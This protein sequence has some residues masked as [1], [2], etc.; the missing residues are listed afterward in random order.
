MCGVRERLHARTFIGRSRRMT[1]KR[2][3]G[4]ELSVS[5]Q[6]LFPLS[7]CVAPRMEGEACLLGV[8]LLVH[9]RPGEMVVAQVSECL[10]RLWASL[11]SSWATWSKGLH[12]SKNLGRYS[13]IVAVASQVAAGSTRCLAAKWLISML[14][15]HPCGPQGSGNWQRDLGLSL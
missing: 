4:A 15:I 2:L 6:S 8:L 7:G 3:G 14:L 11:E 13:P 10:S 12:L 9:T 5:G 1:S